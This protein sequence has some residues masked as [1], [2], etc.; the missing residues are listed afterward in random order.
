MHKDDEE[1]PEVLNKLRSEEDSENWEQLANE[2]TKGTSDIL[3]DAAI[4]AVIRVRKVNKNR[5][6]LGPIL[7]K[8][9][10]IHCVICNNSPVVC[11]VIIPANTRENT[12]GLE[13]EDKDLS[14]VSITCDWHAINPKVADQKYNAKFMVK[15]F[16]NTEKIQEGQKYALAI[17]AKGKP[18]PTESMITALLLE[19]HKMINWLQNKIHIPKQRFF[20]CS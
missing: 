15:T 17:N 4:F 13:Q 18:F 7:G 16:R 6:A 1:I 14:F 8:D 9:G 20:K 5:A 3:I 19:Q 10:S 12:T 2:K 11:A